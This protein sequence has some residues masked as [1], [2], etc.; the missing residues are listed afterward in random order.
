MCACL[1]V[2]ACMCMCAR[3]RVCDDICWHSAFVGVLLIH[4]TCF[5]VDK[6][7]GK[8]WL[9][10]FLVQVNG[11]HLYWHSA[12]M[13][14]SGLLTNQLLPVSTPATSY[15]NRVFLVLFPVP[16]YG[17]RADDESLT[18]NSKR[19]PHY[20]V[21]AGARVNINTRTQGSARRRGW[22]RECFVCRGCGAHFSWELYNGF[23]SWLVAVVTNIDVQRH[24]FVKNCNKN[25]V[26]HRLYI[27]E[28]NINSAM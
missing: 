28:N 2:C 25:D 17:F 19:L 3:A 23:H 10:Q 22:R 7:L 5:V 20:T 24:V 27:K 16:T 8:H 11:R 1:H 4:I 9:K 18:L 6:R 21:G 15:T 13:I 26:I 12:S 14:L